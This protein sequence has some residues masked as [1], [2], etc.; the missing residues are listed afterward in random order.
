L[1]LA[2]VATLIALFVFMVMPGDPKAN[3]FGPNPLNPTSEMKNDL[4]DELDVKPAKSVAK[5]EEEN[6]DREVE[7]DAQNTVIPENARYWANA[8]A[9]EETPE[10]KARVNMP[11]ENNDID[12]KAQKYAETALK[13]IEYRADAGSVWDNIQELPEKYHGRFL[14]DLGKNPKCDVYELE[15]KILAER[16]KSLRPFEN[17]LANDILDDMRTIGPEAESEFKEVYEILSDTVCP[18]DLGKQIEAKFGPSTRTELLRK[19]KGDAGLL[20]LFS[21]AD[22]FIFLIVCTFIVFLIS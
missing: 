22:I 6:A 11:L 21:G 15:G 14:E 3:Q 18:E 5:V 20:G 1:G 12:E 7:P 9:A 2:W 8:V 19:S 17:Q 13:V 4:G 16:K 10:S